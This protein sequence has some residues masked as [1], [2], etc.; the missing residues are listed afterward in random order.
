MGAH[1]L[2]KD[3]FEQGFHLLGSK[4][5][6]PV[7]LVFEP[8]PL[9]YAHFSW[10]RISLVKFSKPRNEISG[11]IFCVHGEVFASYRRAVFHESLLAPKGC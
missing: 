6:N 3:P 9:F 1:I 2:T 10:I 4:P 11:E 8:L 7:T 5:W